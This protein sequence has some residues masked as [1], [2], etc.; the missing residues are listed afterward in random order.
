MAAG[1]ADEQRAVGPLR[2]TDG[3]LTSVTG[4]LLTPRLLAAAGNFHAD[5]GVLGAL[6]LVGR[7]FTTAMWTAF[8]FGVIPNNGVGKLDLANVLTVHIDYIKLC[9]CSF[10]PYAFTLLARVM[11]VPWNREPHP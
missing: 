10:P 9:H 3:A 8:S 11:M 1:W 2:S 7:K 6:T 5:L 4:A